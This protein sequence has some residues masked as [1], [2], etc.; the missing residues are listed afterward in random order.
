MSDYGGDD[1]AGGFGEYANPPSTTTEGK[2]RGELLLTYC[3][4]KGA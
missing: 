2:D 1:D 3:P 4:L